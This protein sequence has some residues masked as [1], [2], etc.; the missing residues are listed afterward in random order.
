[1]WIFMIVHIETCWSKYIKG[2]LYVIFCVSLDLSIGG[3]V[4][5]EVGRVFGDEL[6]SNVDNEFG[7]V[8]ES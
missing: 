3:V 5:A 7:E 4:F 1:M 8:V 6:C 2:E